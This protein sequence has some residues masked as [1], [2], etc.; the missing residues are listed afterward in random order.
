MG[1]LDDFMV[2]DELRKLRY[3]ATAVLVVLLLWLGIQVYYMI[4][5][6]TIS[7][8]VTESQ[9]RPFMSW[10]S[11]RHAMEQGEF[12]LAL[13]MAT[14]MAERHP[15]YY[16]AHSYL[17]TIYLAQGELEEA[18]QAYERAYELLPTEDNR[19]YLEAVRAR[20]N[21]GTEAEGVR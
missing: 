18:E 15:D 7:V 9:G 14:D 19:K 6:L 20:L 2:Y 1:E 3:I 8:R 13:G 11:T 17:G 5:A 12:D 16:Y 21:K 4:R 10:E